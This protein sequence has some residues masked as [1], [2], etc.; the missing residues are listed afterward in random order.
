MVAVIKKRR[1]VKE[2]K[3]MFSQV[4]ICWKEKVRGSVS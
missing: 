4:R 3:E 2:R 1:K